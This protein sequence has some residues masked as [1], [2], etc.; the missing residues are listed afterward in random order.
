MENTE[1]IGEKLIKNTKLSKEHF[2]DAK[3]K[4]CRFAY[5]CCLSGKN[6]TF[7]VPYFSLPH[8]FEIQCE[9]IHCLNKSY[10]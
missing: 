2:R 7:F 9:S 8:L 10:F 4:Q 5:F 3:K 6:G 1:N